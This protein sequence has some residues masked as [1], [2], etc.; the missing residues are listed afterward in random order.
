MGHT[1]QLRGLL[2]CSPTRNVDDMPQGHIIMSTLLPCK[3]KKRP[4]PATYDRTL[5]L[6]SAV[7]QIG[8]VS[9]YTVLGAV[10]V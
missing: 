6:S 8:G 4:W 2:P 5:Q 1:L 10:S 7:Q 9:H 3:E